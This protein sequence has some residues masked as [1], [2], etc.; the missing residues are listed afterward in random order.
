VTKGKDWP[1][2]KRHSKLLKL[3]FASKFV[4]VQIEE[5]YLLHISEIYF[6]RDSDKTENLP[7]HTIIKLGS[8]N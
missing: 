7:E 8:W 2:T 4:K 1:L 3:L 6:P 5:R